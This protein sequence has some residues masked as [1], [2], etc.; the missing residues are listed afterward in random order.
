MQLEFVFEPGAGTRKIFIEEL[1]LAYYSCRKNKRNTIN[2]LAF[3]VDYENN[4]LTLLEE[5][6]TETYQPGR[7]VTF[8]VTK[9]VKREIFAADFRDRIVQHL[10]INKLNNLFEK[11]FIYD[12]YACRIGKGTH[13][14]IKRADNFIRRCSQNYSQDCYILKLDIKGFFM[15]IDK[16]ILFRKLEKFIEEK[17]YKPDK[18]LIIQLCQKI[19]YHNP[20]LNCLVKGK[21]SDWKGLPHGKSLFDTSTQ[22]GLPIGNLTSQIFANFYMNTFD[23]FIKHTLGIRFY[24]R[25]VNDIIFVH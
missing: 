23:H 5:I 14:G 19:I 2:A 22:C 3:E 16:D 24:G 18:Q 12:I 20:T 6:N 11:E 10:I 21:R 1:F 25:Y 9:P 13:M 7:S 17:Y 8:V 15:S 4:L